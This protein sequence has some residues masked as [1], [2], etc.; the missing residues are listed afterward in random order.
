MQTEKITRVGPPKQK[1]ISGADFEAMRKVT[2]E[3][4]GVLG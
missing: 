3:Q 1:N 2:S 4:L